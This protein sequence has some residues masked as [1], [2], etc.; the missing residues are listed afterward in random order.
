[1]ETITQD[2]INDEV[3][4]MAE[5]LDEKLR[6]AGVNSAEQSFGIGCVLALIPILGI[7]VLLFVFKVINLILAVILGFMTTMIL[8]GII[9]LVANLARQNAIRHTYRSSLEN[10]IQFFIDTHHLERTEFDSIVSEKLPRDAPLQ[11]FLQ[12]FSYHEDNGLKE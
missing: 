12:P 8:T 4:Q 6:E 9:A 7:P 1:M 3:S 2:E 11:Q 10:E 5:S